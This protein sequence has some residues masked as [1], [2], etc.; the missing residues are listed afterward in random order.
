[1]NL[2]QAANHSCFCKCAYVQC[3]E[4]FDEFGETHGSKQRVVLERDVTGEA[5]YTVRQREA[6]CFERGAHVYTTQIS[7]SWLCASGLKRVLPVV[8]WVRLLASVRNDNII[9]YKEANGLAQDL[10]MLVWPL[11][12]QIQLAGC[13]T[14]CY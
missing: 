9:D 8:Y 11:N 5:T 10:T 4:L 6:E 1:M 2:H 13:N 12:L 7:Q 3:T 14:T